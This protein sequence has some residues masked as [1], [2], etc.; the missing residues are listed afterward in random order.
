MVNTHKNQKKKLEG[1]YIKL[2]VT[3]KAWGV[4]K[5]RD[6]LRDP[7]VVERHPQ[8]EVTENIWVC[9]KHLPRA[10]TLLPNYTKV[11]KQ[12]DLTED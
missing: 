12:E 6:M 2:A 4:V 10:A 1:D 3:N 5:I 11:D 7:G 8:K 9:Q